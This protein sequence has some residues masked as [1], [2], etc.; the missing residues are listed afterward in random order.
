MNDYY[1]IVIDIIDITFYA[2]ILKT[3]IFHSSS[4]F[5]IY[6]PKFLFWGDYTCNVWSSQN[7]DQI[8][9]A[10]MTYFTAAA[11]LDFRPTELAQGSSL[12]LSSDPSY[13]RENAR[14]LTWLE[15]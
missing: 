11:I 8:Q 15:Q 12:H 5:L 2:H 14:S 1:N 3:Q 6:L 13:C 10:G 7:R 4:N 9:D